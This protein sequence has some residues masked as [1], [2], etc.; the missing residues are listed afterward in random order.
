MRTGPDMVP[1]YQF[2]YAAAIGDAKKQQILMNIV[3]L[4]YAEWPVF[5]EIHQVVAGYNWEQTGSA[6]VSLR[7]MFNAAERDDAELGYVGRFVER[8]TITYAPLGGESFVRNILTP[9]RPE[10]L[11]S[12]IQSGWP[13]D[14][15]FQMM[16]QSVNGK[17]NRHVIYGTDYP[18]DPAFI[19]FVNLLKKIHL[20]NAISIRVRQTEGKGKVNKLN[21]RANLLD[22][23]TKQELDE[24]KA[25]LGLNPDVDTYH[26]IWDSISE[27]PNT[28]AIQTRSVIQVM[29]AM[30]LYVELS[31]EE[32]KKGDV[33]SLKSTQKDD[34]ADLPPLMRIHSGSGTPKDAFVAVRYHNRSFWIDFHDWNSKISLAYLTLLLTVTESGEM[35]GPQLTI[36]TN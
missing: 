16:V 8:P 15:L 31:L 4:R 11:L 23:E 24:M 6:K 29:V 3:K 36:S 14:R 17:R 18:A 35:K 34:A 27:D 33:M 13:V 10:S 5:L 2:D 25:M 19:S 32:I 30:A 9:A 7:R 26:I 22:S 12:L 20:A 1:R 21:F 28:I